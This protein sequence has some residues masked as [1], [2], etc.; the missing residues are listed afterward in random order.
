MLTERQEKI[1]RAIV[2]EYIVHAEP[3]G[4]RTVSKRKDI[5]FSAATV[6]MRWPTWKRW[7]SWNSRIHLPVVYPVR[8]A[9]AIMSITD[10]P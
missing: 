8:L 7:V 2:D 1:L 4:S 6:R 3:V 5:G 9:T 10:G